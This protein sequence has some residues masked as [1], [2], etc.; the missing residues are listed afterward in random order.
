MGGVPN[1]SRLFKNRRGIQL[2]NENLFPGQVSPDGSSSLETV[3]LKCSESLNRDSPL[4]NTA[5]ERALIEMI[6]NIPNPENRAQQ[7][8]GSKC[9]KLV[10]AKKRTER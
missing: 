6:N 9:K 4:K 5:D 7:P 8:A 2:E 3:S 10:S 1:G